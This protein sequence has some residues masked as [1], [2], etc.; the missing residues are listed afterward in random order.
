MQKK[1]N[2]RISETNYIHPKFLHG[3]IGTAGPLD[4]LYLGENAEASEHERRCERVFCL[5]RYPLDI[6]PLGRTQIDEAQ[7]ED[8]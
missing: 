4:K 2:H 8:L 7:A 3:S 1:P 5:L 6:S